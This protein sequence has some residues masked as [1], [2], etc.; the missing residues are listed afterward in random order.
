MYFQAE[1]TLHFNLRIV[2]GMLIY[3]YCIY[4]YYHSVSKMYIN[5]LIS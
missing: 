3:Y 1:N 4:N 2:G 5:T